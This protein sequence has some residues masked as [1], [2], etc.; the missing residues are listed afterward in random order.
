M[1]MTFNEIGAAI[2]GSCGFKD[3]SKG[4]SVKLGK[5]GLI[6]SILE[7]PGNY[8]TKL[9]SNLKQFSSGLGIK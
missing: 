3:M 7:S 1:G 8:L 6:Q 5:T 2:L 9:L 4:F